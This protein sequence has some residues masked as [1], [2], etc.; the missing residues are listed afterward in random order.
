MCTKQQMSIGC[1]L[2]C[3]LVIDIGNLRLE[4][5]DA[6]SQLLDGSRDLGILGIGGEI[7]R[8]G[9]LALEQ[10]EFNVVGEKEELGRVCRRHGWL[11]GG[12]SVGVCGRVCKC[13]CG[14]C[15]RG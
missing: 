9:A 4:R 13:E 10:R 6:R 14:G 15:G 5:F 3:L 1:V 8:D 11:A 2:G 12:G 7:E